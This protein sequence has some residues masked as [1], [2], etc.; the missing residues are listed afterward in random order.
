MKHAIILLLTSVCVFAQTRIYHKDGGS[1]EG[2]ILEAN[3][4]H[5]VFQR[6]E[7]LQQFRMKVEDLALLLPHNSSIF[8]YA[9]ACATRVYTELLS[10]R[11][12]RYGMLAHNLCPSRDLLYLHPPLGSSS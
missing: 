4:T 7:D 5:L 6:A 3:G 8:A 10:Y 11:W 2:K 1:V 12:A 9:G